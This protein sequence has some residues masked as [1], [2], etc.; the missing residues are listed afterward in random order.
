MHSSPQDR[1][2]ALPQERKSPDWRLLLAYYAS[3][4]AGGGGVEALGH[5]TGKVRFAAGDG[6]VAHGFGHENGVL[7]FGNSGV[8]EDAVSAELHS[9]GGVGGGADPGVDDER[10][11]R[12][13][14]AED[15]QIR[16][17]LDAKARADGRGQ[18]HHGSSSSVDEFAGGD[19]IVIRVRED[20]EAFFDQH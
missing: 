5:T 20:Y 6:G 1:L 12:D 14:F 17:V 11:F 4:R 8:H 13:A 18:R 19:Q 7:G 15:A 2:A 3:E 9:F 10:D 16:G